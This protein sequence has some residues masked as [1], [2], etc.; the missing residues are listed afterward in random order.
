MGFEQLVYGTQIGREVTT[1]DGIK[2]MLL[3]EIKSDCH[4]AVRV[5]DPP[6]HQVFFIHLTEDEE[7]K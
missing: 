6:P 7:K 1:D 2:W 4:L 5:D 3:A